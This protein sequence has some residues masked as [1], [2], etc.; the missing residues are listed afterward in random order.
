ML[1][2]IEYGE[3]WTTL[4]DRMEW[5]HSSEFKI[6]KYMTHYTSGSPRPCFLIIQVD[7]GVWPGYFSV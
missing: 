3:V 7:R 2:N 1:I 6:C 4:R 5:A